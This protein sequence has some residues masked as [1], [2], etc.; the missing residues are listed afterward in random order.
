VRDHW[1]VNG[2]GVFGDVKILVY[3]S[4]GVGKERS[5]R[6]NTTAIFV[7]LRN[8]AG[9]D[10]DQAVIGNFHF[11]VKLEQA[12]S[13]TPVLWTGASTAQDENHGVGSLKLREFA[14]LPSVLGKL[15][16]RNACARE[17]VRIS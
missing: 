17:K 16:V 5:V 4:A 11:T 7:G 13:L 9:A 2:V 10:R 6:S 14:V 1:I 8:V 12:L 15:I 3:D